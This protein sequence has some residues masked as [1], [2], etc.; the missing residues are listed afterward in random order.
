VC[1]STTAVVLYVSLSF[2]PSTKIIKNV[3]KGFFK[4]LPSSF[5]LPPKEKGVY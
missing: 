1:C 5:L 4:V 3:L 2:F